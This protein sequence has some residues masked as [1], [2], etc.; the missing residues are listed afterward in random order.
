[1]WW[2]GCSNTSPLLYPCIVFL[3]T[4]FTAPSLLIRL[5]YPSPVMSNGV[6]RPPSLWQTRDRPVDR[7]SL[8]TNTPALL[9]SSNSTVYG[10][11]V[12]QPG[13]GCTPPASSSSHRHLLSSPLPSYL[14]VHTD[15]QGGERI[16]LCIRCVPHA[17]AVLSPSFVGRL[18]CYDARF[19][20]S[21]AKV[22]GVYA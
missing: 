10:H 15:K 18:R 3:V 7:L 17:C 19:S 6:R 5:V 21:F 14:F 8:E 22:L 1:M 2:R 12:R 9:A 16:I 11:E 20:I 4:L 13:R